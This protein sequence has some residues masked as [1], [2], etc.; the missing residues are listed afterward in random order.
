M[1]ASGAKS[2]AVPCA[3]AV[4]LKLPARQTAPAR[5]P[6]M[7]PAYLDIGSSRWRS[8]A[9]RRI[10][11]W[12]THAGDR[13]YVAMRLAADIILQ[14]HVIALLV[15]EARLPIAGVVLRIVDGDDVLDLGR[16]DPAD[17]LECVHLV[18]VRRAGGVDERLLVEAG[19]LDHQ[20]L[21]VEAADRM[22]VEIRVGDQL[23]VARQGLVHL[24]R[25]DL[26]V[27]LVHKRDLPARRID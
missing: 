7:H 15:D 24:D 23:L 16:A 1:L 19:R 11:S 4:K 3:I 21:A 25:A 27:E 14:P 2:G 20:R 26:V 13:R 17:A 18:G 22:P 6:V 5:T 12:T 10:G 9:K 8:G